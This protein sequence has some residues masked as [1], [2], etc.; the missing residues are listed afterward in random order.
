[1]NKSVRLSILPAVITACLIGAGAASAASYTVTSTADAVAVDP[2]VGCATADGSCTLRSAIQAANAAG[3]AN[4]ITLPAGTY[5]LT[6]APTGDDGDANGDL[7][8]TAG[9]LTITGAGASSTTI[10]ANHIDRAFTV[11][12]GASLEL[13]GVTVTNGQPAGSGASSLCPDNVDSPAY[14]GAI[15][16][17]GTL[18]LSGDVLTGNIASGSGGAIAAQGAGADPGPLSISST[19]IAGNSACGFNNPFPYGGGIYA[20][21]GQP[22]TIDHSIVTDNQVPHGDGGGLAEES[23]AAVTVTDS[24]FSSNTAEDGGAL[25]LSAADTAGQVTLTADTLSD[26]T[27]VNNNPGIEEAAVRDTAGPLVKPAFATV[28]FPADGGAINLNGDDV[29]LRNSTVTGNTATDGGGI[30]AGSGTA[31][32]SFSTV[33]GNSASGSVFYN[34]SLGGNLENTDSGNFVLDNSIVAD[35]SVGNGGPGTDCNGP[36]GF[37]SNGHNLFDSSDSGAQCAAVGSDLNGSPDLGPLQDNGGPTQTLALQAGSPAIDA[38]DDSPCAAET[39]RVDQRGVA[40][41]QGPHCD[42]GAY[43]AQVSA[44]LALSAAAQPSSFPVGSSSTVTDTITNNGPSTASGVTF[45]DPTG[46]SISITSAAASQGTCAHSASAVNCSVGAMAPGASVTVAVG[47][48]GTAA[49]PVTLQSSVSASTPDPNLA[50]N[51]ATV[52]MTVTATPS[53]TPTPHAVPSA[54]LALAVHASPHRVD[55]GRR[56]TLTWTVTNRGPDTDSGVVATLSLPRSLRWVGYHATGGPCGGHRTVRCTLGTL[57]SG[58]HDTIRIVTVATRTGHIRS[59][60]HVTGTVTDPNLHNNDAA[61]TVAVIE[62]PCRQN[63]RFATSWRPGLAMR[64][65][66]VYVDGRLVKVRHGADLRAVTVAPLPRTGAHS[67]TV[68][69]SAG[70]LDTVAVTRTYNGC[71]TGQTTYAYPPQTNPGAS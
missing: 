30:A 65:V 21:T 35:G 43:E 6:I 63:L 39:G 58:A 29:A 19:T 69:F 38:A 44:D 16:D 45:T 17:N 18:T 31:T 8:V 15:L 20:S 27:A 51:Q 14:G 47:V 48:T 52:S 71:S 13:D 9:S 4:T 42:I 26:N 12:D 2:S 28:S 1:M 56:V 59:T 70:P 61:A 60:G 10:D 53:P 3:G 40:R 66:K 49:G 5:T 62:P 36:S 7:N 34:S 50:N 68:A 25:D 24:T 46:G 64:T 41:P 32:I 11:G 22:V 33:D 54:D 55:R 37:T 23:G 57:A 67:V